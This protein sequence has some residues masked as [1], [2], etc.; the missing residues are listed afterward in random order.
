MRNTNLNAKEIASFREINELNLDEITVEKLKAIG[1]Q[2]DDKGYVEDIGKYLYTAGLINLKELLELNSKGRITH[3]CFFHKEEKPSMS[4]YTKINKKYKYSFVIC[5][6]LGRPI[7]FY[8]I[9]QCIEGSYDTDK[10]ANHKT[11]FKF[12]RET[13]AENNHNNEEINLVELA[14]DIYHKELLNKS[15][16]SEKVLNYLYGR[17]LNEESIKRHKIGFCFNNSFQKYLDNHNPELKEK[18]KELGLLNKYGY[19]M[20]NGRITLKY[21]FNSLAGRAVAFLDTYAPEGK[22]A[23]KYLNLKNSEGLFN[24]SKELF[25]SNNLDEDTCKEEGIYLCEG[26]FDAIALSQYQTT[27]NKGIN[28]AASITCNLSENQAELL[29]TKTDKIYLMLDSD[30][31]GQK[32]SLRAIENLLKAGFKISDINIITLR[33]SKDLA[34]FFNNEA[35]LKN[36]PDETKY[37]NKLVEEELNNYVSVPEFLIKYRNEQYNNNLI[38]FDEYNSHIKDVFSKYIEDVTLYAK[39]SSM[40]KIR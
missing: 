12:K 37:H 26:Y 4:I 36:S 28:V 40:I 7:S 16:L 10:V 3:L 31:Y 21:S 5:G 27:N 15:E 1:Q 29:K 14:T 6:C 38:T 32:G 17:G 24:K 30:F 2:K 11:S 13:V 9:R 22:E 35:I 20:L 33:N 18:A 23:C 8:N 19:D 25:N 39:Y 34:D